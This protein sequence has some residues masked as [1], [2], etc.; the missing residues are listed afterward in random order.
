MG[1]PSTEFDLSSSLRYQEF[2]LMI[3]NCYTIVSP[4]SCIFALVTVNSFSI[5]TYRDKC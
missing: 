3:V 4:V 1:V 5:S 2:A